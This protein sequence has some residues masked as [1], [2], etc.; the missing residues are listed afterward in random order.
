MINDIYPHK[1]NNH[2]DETAVPKSED[3]VLSFRE[4]DVLAAAD[5][6]ILRFPKVSDFGGN[7]EYTYLFSVDEERF[8][9]LNESVE[10]M[11][12]GYEYKNL[13]GMRGKYPDQNREMYA[14]YTGKHIADWYRD[15]KFCGRCG[16]KMIHSG[17]ERAMKCR[18]CGYTAY[19]RI[20]P[21]VIVGI[22]NGEKILATR[23]R[24]GYKPLALVA[25]FAEIGETI[26]ETVE[27]E[28]MEETGLHVKNIRYYKSQPWGIANDLLFGFFCDVDGDDTIKM[29]D[30]ELSY[31]E[32]LSRDELEVP[33]GNISL[34]NEMMNEFIAGTSGNV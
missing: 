22:L 15:M 18:N 33:A 13:R 2:F 10:S 30:N 19:P 31:A 9:L 26:E 24:V 1:L 20:M 12:S 3:T 25:G 17:T 6:A 23:Y 27:R 16:G 29:D 7:F 32:W 34:T 28:V 21:A 14:A 8:F 4:G 11:P 5:D